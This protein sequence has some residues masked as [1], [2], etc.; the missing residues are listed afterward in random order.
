MLGLADGQPVILTPLSG[1][2]AGVTLAD[3]DLPEQGVEVPSELRT[4]EADYPFSLR[5]SVQLLGLDEGDIPL[6]GKFRDVW[7][8]TQGHAAAQWQAL[9]DLFV[10]QVQVELSW[11][12]LLIRRGV[13]RRLRPTFVSEGAIDYELDF[14]VLEADEATVITQPF[15]PNPPLPY[16]FFDLLD[17]ITGA[18]EDILDAAATASGIV[19]LAV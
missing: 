11:G 1:S 7:G 5:R 8:G 19:Q 13:I 12:D 15:L 10:A 4:S 3:G 18:A 2:T 16:D 6:R 9:R 14:M 17:D